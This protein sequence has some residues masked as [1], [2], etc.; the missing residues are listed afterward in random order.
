M[1]YLGM[2]EQANENVRVLLAIPFL[3]ETDTAID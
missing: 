1:K 3:R 2:L